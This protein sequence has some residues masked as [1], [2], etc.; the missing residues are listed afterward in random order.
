MNRR[1][2]TCWRGEWSPA[3]T[4]TFWRSCFLVHSA[5][6]HRNLSNKQPSS[7]YD[8]S[9]FFSIQVLQEALRVWGLELLPFT[10]QNPAAQ[11]AQRDP[12][13]QKAY[14]CN[15]RQH[16]FCVRKLGHQ[17]FNLNSLLTG[18]ELISDT[19]LSLFL[20]QLQQEGYSLFIVMGELAESEADQLLRI[21][22]AVQPIKPSL[23]TAEGQNPE[24]E[25]AGGARREDDSE[26]QYLQ[27]ALAESR[28]LVEED[29]VALQQALRDSMEGYI[30][31]SISKGDK[32]IGNSSQS[33]SV[34]ACQSNE[35]SAEELRIKRLAF[36]E[37]KGSNP[38]TRSEGKQPSSTPAEGT[39]ED[40]LL[41]DALNLSMAQ[42]K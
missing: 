4:N 20:T 39:N 6:L 41:Q 30:V 32:A 16:W 8:D 17:W 15:F 10:S 14:I 11:A 2:N 13:S 27:R 36:L 29:D 42:P 28:Q 7:N 38:A 21:I 34:S 9:G 33:A 35:P 24:R 3:N 37:G 25:E 22:P 19:Y 12:T 5:V 18:P 23:I 31:D 1:D 26:D 40:A